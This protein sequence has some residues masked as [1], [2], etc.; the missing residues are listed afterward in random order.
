MEKERRTLDI[1]ELKIAPTGHL[2]KVD[3]H[4][5]K[6][7]M[8]AKPMTDQ[9]GLAVC[10]RITEDKW[11]A[12]DWLENNVIYQLL[13]EVPGYINKRKDIPSAFF[14]GKRRYLGLISD[15][16]DSLH[17]FSCAFRSHINL[18]NPLSVDCIIW[19][20][21]GNFHLPPNTLTD[22]YNFKRY[23]PVLQT[24]TNQQLLQIRSRYSLRNS[25]IAELLE[26]SKYTIDKWTTSPDKQS[27]CAMPKNMLDLL[28]RKILDGDY[29]RFSL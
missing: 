2:V 12:Q 26:V 15:K 3:R 23:I 8:M 28:Q 25:Q 9:P 11:L 22:I 17:W 24:N 21:D 16:L 27:H 4:T 6:I 13:W 19:A 18:K 20:S 14:K 1:S 10:A 5:G 7:R 29:N